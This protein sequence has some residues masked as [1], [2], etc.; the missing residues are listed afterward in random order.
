MKRKQILAAVLALAML[1]SMAACADEGQGETTQPIVQNGEKTTYTIEVKSAAGMPMAGLDVY[2]YA[3]DTLQDLEGFGET[4]E[5]GTAKIS[6]PAHDGYAVVLSGAA[7]GYQVASSYPI[8]GNICKISLESQLIDGNLADLSGGD[9]DKLGL[10]DVMYD[11]TVTTAKGETVTLSELLKEKEMVL[12]NFW[13]TTC[14]WCNKEFPYMEQAYQTYKDKIEIV[15]LDPTEDNSVVK[16]YQESMGLSF[17]MAA[18]PYSWA[19]AFGVEYYPTSIVVDRYGVITLIETGGLTS[20]TPFNNMFAF[21]TAEDYEQKLCPNGVA[22]ISVKI[23]PTYTMPSGEEMSA[24]LTVNGAPITYSP[25]TKEGDAE[26]SWPF[27]LGEKDGQ[28]VAY[29]SNQGIDNS[30]SIL[31][32]DVHLKEG[33]AIGFDYLPSCTNGSDI[34]YVLVD[35]KDIYQ[36]SGVSQDGKWNSC[37]PWVA[38]KEG[39]YQVALCFMKDDSEG[40][41]DDTVYVRNFRVVGADEIDAPS[42]IPR[43]AATSDNGFDFTYVDVVLSP[44]D[45]YYHVGSENGP[46][47]LADLTNISQFNEEKTV[48]DMLLEGEIVKDGHNYYDD[49]LPFCSYASNAS[50][51]GVCTVNA[52][53]AEYLKIVAEVAGFDGGENE[54]LKI[55]RYF[56]A[57]GTDGVQLVDP[58]QGLATFSA[59]QATLG[60]DVPTN[61]YYYDRTIIPRGL[62]A[63]FVPT[64]SG[65]YRITSRTETNSS[66]EGWIFDKNMQELM[67]YEMDERLYGDENNVSMVFYMEAGEEYY[68]DIVYW[69]LYETGYIYYDIEYVAAT[70]EHFRLAA[71]GYFTYD[72]NATGEQ[73]YYTV[74]GGI[75]VIEK[76]GKFYQDLGKD[77]SGKQ[78]YG[79]L[80]YADFSG[81]TPVFN[82]PLAQMIDKGGF[83]FTKT[84]NDETI[85]QYM[86]QNDNDPEKTRAYLKEYWGD[87]FEANAENYKLDDVL[88][89]R[90]HGKGTARTEDARQYL[91]KMQTSPLERQGCVEVTTALADLLQALMDKY[92]FANVDYSW[93]KVCYYYDHLGPQ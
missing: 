36:I 23:K 91:S 44:K 64:K 35:G 34:L 5:T 26:Y 2:I 68:I 8:T 77:A 11:F 14:S 50:L 4:D 18:C 85:L 12:L 37:Y 27:I 32:A 72:T 62:F 57:Y 51:S 67:V 87:S 71:P 33:E 13:Y 88:A 9:A 65:V 38:A 28:T 80:L 84:E 31:Y 41:G 16:G 15:A 76:D 93:L 7:K 79:S 55:C 45:G 42:Y 40:E 83:D 74:T 59:L 46:L 49:V 69:D 73:M 24:A 61:Y 53:L 58:I 21:F 30:F 52:E 92:T 6:L 19:S 25:E 70:L 47:L 81:I 82:M 86:A 90:Y 39:D 66:L 56:D 78:R 54:W 3:D 20:V 89:G 29:A 48:F 63:K 1:L 43:Y 17:P 22:D 60:K 10:G 75:K